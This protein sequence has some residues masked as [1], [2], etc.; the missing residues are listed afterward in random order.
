M[1]PPREDPGLMLNQLKTWSQVP[2]WRVA[3]AG[4]HKGVRVINGKQANKKDVF[5]WKW[6]IFSSTLATSRIGYPCLSM[7]VRWAIGIRW[8]DE[9]PFFM[10]VFAEACRLRAAT[11][12]GNGGRRVE[13]GGQHGRGNMG[14]EKDSHNKS[15][16]QRCCRGTRG[17]DLEEHGWK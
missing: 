14:S 5:F 1:K 3:K 15:L 7:L 4:L 11:L 16:R 13:K 2:I 9:G 17:V 10:W 12:M 8:G 6:K